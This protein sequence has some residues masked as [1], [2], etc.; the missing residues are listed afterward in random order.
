MVIL[1]YADARGF[2]DPHYLTFDGLH[3][4]FRGEGEYTVMETRSEGNEE[5]HIQARIFGLYIKS[6]AFGVPGNYSYQVIRHWP[7]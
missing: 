7:C 2:G 1:S 3:Y 5:F 4:V 6:M